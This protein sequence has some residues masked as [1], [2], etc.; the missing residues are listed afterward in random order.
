M[1]VGVAR[2]EGE[3]GLEVGP[4]R[5]EVSEGPMDRTEVGEGGLVVGPQG[6]CREQSRL[7]PT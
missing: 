2:I 7:G 1:R 4:R 3:N 6:E 5:F